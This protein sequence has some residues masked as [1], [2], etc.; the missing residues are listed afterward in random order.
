MER[1]GDL[2][3]AILDT[4]ALLGKIGH[5]CCA[6]LSDLYAQ[7]HHFWLHYARKDQGGWTAPPGQMPTLGKHTLTGI[8]T[9]IRSMICVEPLPGNLTGTLEAVQQTA[10]RIL[11]D[12]ATHDYLEFEVLA[13][14][15]GDDNL[16]A[17]L[18]S[19]DAR[20]PQ[21]NGESPLQQLLAQLANAL[22][23][24]L[25]AILRQVD[26]GPGVQMRSLT[27]R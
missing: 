23:F 17:A 5:V 13:V 19:F 6:H 27:T 18:G 26:V 2:R 9:G 3:C 25:V 15:L 10:A 20:Y 11:I 7:R 14:R 1:L 8:D 12:N 22:P 21:D 16:A 4:P 24:D